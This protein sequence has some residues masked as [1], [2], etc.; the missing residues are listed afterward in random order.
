MKLIAILCLSALSALAQSQPNEVIFAGAHYTQQSTPN[1]SGFVGYGKKITEGGI[2]SYTLIRETSITVKPKPQL[3][4]A[5]ETGVAARIGTFNSFD[6]YAIATGG[7]AAAGS[8]TGTTAGFSASGMVMA[9][10]PI[11]KGWFYGLAGG[12][13]Y[14]TIKGDGVAYQVGIVLGWGK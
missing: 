12:P 5:T 14:S 2:Y 3:K 13:T 9:A 10:H 4:T 8:T 1:L 11:G 7:I 6:L